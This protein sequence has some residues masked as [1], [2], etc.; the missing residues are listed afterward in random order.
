MNVEFWGVGATAASAHPMTTSDVSSHLSVDWMPALPP[1][2]GTSLMGWPPFLIESLPF[3]NYSVL[4]LRKDA[5]RAERQWKGFLSWMLGV[6][7]TRHILKAENYRWIAPLSAFYPEAVQP[8]DLT[9]WHPSFPP[10][11]VKATR[12]IGNPSRL[13]PDYVALRSTT[14][15]VQGQR[16]DWAVA[17]SKGTHIYL[18]GDK[19]CPASWSSQARNVVISVDDSEIDIP[20]YLVIATRVNP[21]AKRDQTRRIQIRAWNSRNESPHI[22]LPKEAT[23]DI[24]AAHLFGLFGSLGLREAA[25]AVAL[26]S[27]RRAERL[28]MVDAHATTYAPDI[29]LEH[30]ERELAQRNRV[31]IETAVGPIKIE[32]GKPLVNLAKGLWRAADSSDAATALEKADIQLDKWEA[33]RRGRPRRHTDVA[34]PFGVEVNL[35]HD[36]DRRG[37]R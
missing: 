31:D 30:A 8:V 17:E 36:F 4:T 13:R 25:R 14:R 23:V 21:N 12:Q 28:H 10:T 1:T 34:L 22:D 6:A 18:G 15:R 32:I 26:S 9:K 11:S 37:E 27:Q 29:V 16:Y 24:V 20:R 2:V 7:G 3:Q 35:P 33:S 5:G 19:S